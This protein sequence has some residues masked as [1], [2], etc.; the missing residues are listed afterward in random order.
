MSINACFHQMCGFSVFA[1][2]SVNQAEHDKNIHIPYH[3]KC[4]KTW[5]TPCWLNDVSKSESRCL[6]PSPLRPPY[7]IVRYRRTCVRYNL[8]VYPNYSPS[9]ATNFSVSRL[10]VE[11]SWTER[12]WGVWCFRSSSFGRFIAISRSEAVNMFLCGWNN[13]SVCERE[14][15]KIQ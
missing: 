1:L 14:I 2:Q 3:I 5:S 13:D 9:A 10:R 11:Y 7:Y 6:H 8:H 15:G 12:R 4:I